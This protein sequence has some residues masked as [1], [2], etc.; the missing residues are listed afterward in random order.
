[1]RNVTELEVN[2]G[3]GLYDSEG[4]IDTLISDCNNAVRACVGG[5]YIAFCNTMVQMVQKLARLKTGIKNDFTSKDQYIEQLKN[6]LREQ[7]VEIKEVP[8]ERLT[9]IIG[10]KSNGKD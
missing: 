2:N 8:A 1:M 10:R 5:Q 3:R 6:Q 9:E 4:L 7:G